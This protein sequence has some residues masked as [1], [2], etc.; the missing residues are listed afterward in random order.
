MTTPISA[1][2]V[3]SKLNVKLSFIPAEIS[4]APQEEFSAMNVTAVTGDARKY[5]F[6]TF[7]RNS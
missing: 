4:R 5:I 1:I 3:H 6:L 2:L 7:Q